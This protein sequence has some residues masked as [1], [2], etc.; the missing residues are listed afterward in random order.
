[1]KN[2]VHAALIHYLWEAPLGGGPGSRGRTG[3]A[4]GG[5]RLLERAGAAWAGLLEAGGVVAFHGA[6]RHGVAAATRRGGGLLDPRGNGLD[7]GCEYKG[8][9]RR[10]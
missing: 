8:R 4:T 2:R 10:I 5:H 9:S 3:V 1:M 7:L 6:A